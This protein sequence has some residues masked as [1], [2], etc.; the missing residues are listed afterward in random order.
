[1]RRSGLPI[2]LVLI[3]LSACG[4]GEQNTLPT[5]I[6]AE[7]LPTVIAMTAETLPTYTPPPP[8]QVITPTVAIVTPTVIVSHVA[9]ETSLPDVIQ[10]SEA[11]IQIVRPG[12][13]SKVVS[14]MRISIYVIPGAERKATVE[15]WGEDG[16][17]MYRRIFTFTNVND[18]TQI[19]EEISFELAGAAEAARLVARTHDEYGRIISLASTPIIL[20]A[21]GEE[22]LYAV[23]DVMNPILIQSPVENVLIQGVNLLVT[24]VA[25]TVSDEPLL[26]ELVAADGRVLGS[27]LAGFSNFEPGMH[28][29]FAVEI[30]LGVESPTWVRVIVSERSGDDISPLNSSSVEVLLS[31]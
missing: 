29:F 25:R 22:D 31:P 6:P 14:P 19:Y 26:V 18:R 15:L 27:R 1:M 11:D 10:I 5:L 20:L 13:L 30:P 9:V 24:G 23:N 28:N 17:L 16:R 8:M 21:E 4:F 3:A 12:A 7:Y 2:V